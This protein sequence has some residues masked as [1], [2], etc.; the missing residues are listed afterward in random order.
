[1]RW[2]K[3]LR[4]GAKD[5]LELSAEMRFG[6]KI[7]FGGRGLARITLTN[8]LLGQT[9][10]QFPQPLAGRTLQVLLEYP[11]QVTF[12]HGAKRRHFCR[13]EFGLL[14]HPLPIL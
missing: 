6:R 2:S 7:H 10:L 9:A 3:R 5:L 13:F 14:R 8:K 4:R 12:G 11:L 1:M